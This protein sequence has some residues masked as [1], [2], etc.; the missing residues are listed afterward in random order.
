MKTI[1]VKTIVKRDISIQLTHNFVKFNMYTFLYY[2]LSEDDR[3][4]VEI[5]FHRVT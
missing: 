3:T 5:R 1:Y 2:G 4:T